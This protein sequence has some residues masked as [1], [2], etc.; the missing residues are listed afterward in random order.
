MILNLQSLNNSNQANILYLILTMT[1]QDV[2]VLLRSNWLLPRQ[3]IK[4]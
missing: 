3:N 4:H 2:Q 1:L